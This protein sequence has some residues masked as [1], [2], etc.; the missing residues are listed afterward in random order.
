VLRQQRLV[1]HRHDLAVDL[2][3]RRK[4]GG[5]EEVGTILLRHQAQQFV[6]EL[7]RLIVLHAFLLLR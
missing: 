6:H 3:R 5:D 2:D 1:G 4:I 7:Q